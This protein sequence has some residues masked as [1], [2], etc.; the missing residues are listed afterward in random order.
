MPVSRQAKGP[1]RQKAIVSQKLFAILWL[2]LLDF[3]AHK[4]GLRGPQKPKHSAIV[5]VL[6]AYLSPLVT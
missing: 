1:L 2:F 3:R 6:Q 4:C 5:A